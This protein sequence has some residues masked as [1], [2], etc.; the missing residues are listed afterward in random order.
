MWSI[1]GI[2]LT[3][4]MSMELWWNGTDRADKYGALVE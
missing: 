4:E 1:G 2:I 3:G